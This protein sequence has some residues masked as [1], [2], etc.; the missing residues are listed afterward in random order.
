MEEGIFSSETGQGISTFKSWPEPTLWLS[1]ELCSVLGVNIPAW[2]SMYLLLAANGPF[3]GFFCFFSS[4]L[5]CWSCRFWWQWS[6]MDCFREER[7]SSGFSNIDTNNSDTHMDLSSNWLML[8]FARVIVGIS[9]RGFLLLS[10]ASFTQTSR[11]RGSHKGF[12]SV[13]CSCSSNKKHTYWVMT[14]Q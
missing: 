12:S 13:G 5:C 14:L 2:S 1:S 9:T 6:S 8:A 11:D 3:P 7:E 4:L 10:V